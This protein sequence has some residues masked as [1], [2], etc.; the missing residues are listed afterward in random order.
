[1][2][3]KTFVV[4]SVSDRV[5]ELNALVGQIAADSRFDSYDVNLYFQDPQGVAGKIAHR[6]RYERVIVVPELAGCHG[7]RVL[8]L[9][10]LDGAGYDAYVNLDDDMELCGHTDYEPAVAF[11]GYPGIGFVMTNWAKTMPLL[12]KKVPAMLR[13]RASGMGRFKRQIMLYNG[14]GMV[15]RDRVADLMRQLEPVKTAFDCAWPITSYVNGFENYRDQGS[16]AVHKVCGTGGMNAFMAATKLHVMCEEWLEF[17][18]AKKQDG[19]C[20]SVLIPLDAQVK[21]AAKEAH[22]K[23]RREMGL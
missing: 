17:L 8:L 23:A 12:E 15:Y 2:G 13:H 1:M 22:A 7:A 18:P 16:L 4:I 19:S 10:E 5:G 9:R 20:T 11:S 6:D 21:Q 3:R 14:G